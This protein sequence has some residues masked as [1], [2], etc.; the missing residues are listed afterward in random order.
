MPDAKKQ[1][2]TIVDE[3]QARQEAEGFQDQLETFFLRYTSMATVLNGIAKAVDLEPDTNP[4]EIVH[5]L[6]AQSQELEQ[7]V[8]VLTERA[9]TAESFGT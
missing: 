4:V 7:K 3:T 8:Y 6:V 2:S 1:V 5:A 9:E